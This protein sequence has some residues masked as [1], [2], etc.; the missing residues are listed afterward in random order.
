MLSQNLWFYFWTLLGIVFI[1][2]AVRKWKA[3]GSLQQK[4]WLEQKIKERTEELLE[5]K[6][7]IKRKNLLLEQKQEKIERQNEELQR[8]NGSLEGMV[9]QRTAQLQ[10]A[11]DKVLHSTRELDNFI[12][13]APHDFR[14]PIARLLG[15]V[16]LAKMETQSEGALGYLDKIEFTAHRM[17][18]ML[19]KLMKVYELERAKLQLE[20][21]DMAVEIDQTIACIEGYLSIERCQFDFKIDPI[22][23]FK[24]D[25]N[26]LRIILTNL[27]ENSIIYSSKSL[28]KSHITIHVIKQ[29]GGILLSVSD[30]GMGISQRIEPYILEPFYKGTDFSDGNGLGL[31]LVDKAV[32]KLEGEL[33][34]SS[35]P[36]ECT[37]FKV[38]LPLLSHELINN[39]SH[40]NGIEI[41]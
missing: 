7:E 20:E 34:F 12:Y 37:V 8:L 28:T 11:L 2:R 26:C 38:F 6:A 3:L 27:I 21:V 32:E 31:F 15:L 25:R 13:K 9:N 40:Q 19:G 4:E 23:N 41:N 30:N 35:N 18:I 10:K 29:S 16:R 1:S 39:L 36:H 17:D 22:T 24:T 5:R 14:G 33:S